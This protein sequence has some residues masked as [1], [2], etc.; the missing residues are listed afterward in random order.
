VPGGG[1]HRP[2]RVV[3]RLDVQGDP[4]G[5]GLGQRRQQRLGVGHHEVAVEV[6]AGVGPQGGDHRRAEG[7]IGD[8]V[9]VHEVQVD[10]VGGLLDQPD[11]IG[12]L[13]EVG[14]QHRR[15]QASD[16]GTPRAGTMVAD[17]IGGLQMESEPAIAELTLP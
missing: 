6:A 4:V 10:P 17:A 3:Q 13:G 15:G 7:E 2:R 9:P 5:P 14:V 8:E 16:H 11:L 12:E 1:A